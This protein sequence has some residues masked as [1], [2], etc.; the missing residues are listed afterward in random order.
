MNRINLITL[1][2]KDIRKSLQFY[3]D[4]GFEASVTGDEEQPVI[5]FFNNEGSK[6]ELF[7]LEELAKDINKENPPVLSKDGFPGFTLAYNAKSA[8]EVDDIIQL[9]KKVG[10]EVVKEPQKLSWGGYGGYFIDPDGYY[11]E[12]AYGSLWEFDDSNMLIM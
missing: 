3:R 8:K 1:G 6:L 12:V 7:P 5:V 11:W 10:A 9:V 2:V 4:I